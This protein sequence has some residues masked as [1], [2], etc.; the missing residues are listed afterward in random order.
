MENKED[1]EED[2][3]VDSDAELLASPD[4]SRKKR[5]DRGRFAWYDEQVPPFALWVAGSDDLVD[6]KRLLRRFERGREPHVE[7]VHSKIIEGYEH[8]D[9][10]WAIDS[11]EQVG[12]EVLETIWRTLPI[13][14]R[15]GTCR[16]P[17]GC[18]NIE[19]WNSRKSEGEGEAKVGA[20]EDDN[21]VED[22]D[23]ERWQEGKPV[24][25]ESR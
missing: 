4:S 6:G 15:E 16:V 9:V 8:L 13:E 18:E 25:S 19:F 17:V 22:L 1:E 2:L 3:E 11:I 23:E 7:I 12:R 10:I 20:A 21:G 5:K 14:L 24:D